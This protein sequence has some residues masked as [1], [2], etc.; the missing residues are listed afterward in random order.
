MEIFSAMRI[1]DRDINEDCVW[2]NI[3]GE[4]CFA[5]VADGLGGYASGEEASGIVVDCIGAAIVGTNISEESLIDAIDNA[6]R[7]ILELQAQ[8]H[9]RCMSTVALVWCDNKN[10]RMF[11]IHVGD[12]RIYQ[13][14]N[15]RIVYQSEDHSVAQMA[16]HAGIIKASDIRTYPKRNRLVRALGAE[17]SVKIDCSHLESQDSD[18]IIICSDGFWELISE[19][20]LLKSLSVHK[21]IKLSI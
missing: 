11:T 4:H 5:T 15:N 10:H 21:N 16:V 1:G 3:Q 18:V 12:T 9:K 19:E 8:K 2:S 6:N 7:R 13:I 17:N 14:R 20:N